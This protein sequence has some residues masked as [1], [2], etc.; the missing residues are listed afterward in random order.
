MTNLNK[1]PY[2]QRNIDGPSNIYRTYLYQ[3]SFFL[4]AKFL[5]NS[6]DFFQ[7]LKSHITIYVVLTSINYKHFIQV[8]LNRWD[9]DNDGIENCSVTEHYR[10]GLVFFLYSLK[11]LEGNLPDKCVETDWRVAE[12]NLY[13][14]EHQSSVKIVVY[15][16]LDKY[17]VDQKT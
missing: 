6:K 17:V 8:H 4:T 14:L 12:N 7:Y 15:Y 5:T 2:K 16:K 9:A 10:F 11:V 1:H 13:P 3:K